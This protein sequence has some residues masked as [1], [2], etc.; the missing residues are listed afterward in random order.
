L[1]SGP[2][3]AAQQAPVSIPDQNDQFCRVT[4]V[5]IIHVIPACCVLSVVSFNDL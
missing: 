1:P 5:L 2:E 3:K 4:L